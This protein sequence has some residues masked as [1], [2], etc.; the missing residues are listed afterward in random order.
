MLDPMATAFFLAGIGR[1][2]T[3]ALATVFA[4]HPDIVLGVERFKKL[5][6]DRILEHTPD[7]L[8]DR[9]KF[10]DFSDGH[11]NLTPDS[12]PR[13]AEHYRRMSEKWDQARYVG[14]KMTTARPQQLWKNHPD[15]RFV[16]IVRDVHGVANSWDTR[17]RN[18]SDKH[19]PETADGARAANQWNIQVG[20]MRRAVRERPEQ[21]AIVEYA[22]FFG[23][24]E[25][26]AF[27]SALNWL[28][29]E[30]EPDTDCEFAS[31]HRQYVNKIADKPSNLSS[32]TVA[33]VD[34][35]AD[36]DLWRDVQG[37]AL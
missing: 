28:G 24:P 1:S 12:S 3:T 22:D 6:G 13:W 20:R 29:L 4:A 15:A 23:D 9:D 34:E 2:G 36:Q 11:T 10:F 33:E 18:P 16:F 32:Q 17:A 5:W 30:R 8:A 19:W 26:R 25:G 27:G 37:L 21:A 31:A 7:L 14:D 35:R